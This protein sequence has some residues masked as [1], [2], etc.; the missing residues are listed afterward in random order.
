MSEPYRVI[1]ALPT[2]TAFAR[3]LMVKAAAAGTPT[4]N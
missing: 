3:F 2:G 1:S 4:P